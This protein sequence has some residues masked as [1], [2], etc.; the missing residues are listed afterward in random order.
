M[1]NDGGEAD[2]LTGGG[3]KD[4]YIRALNDV[5]T[6]RELSAVGDPFDSEFINLL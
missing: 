4:W 1:L 6:D 2:V 5:I 3:S